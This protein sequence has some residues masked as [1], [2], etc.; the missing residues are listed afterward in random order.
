MKRGPHLRQDER[1]ASRRPC[2]GKASHRLDP[3]APASGWSTTGMRVSRSWRPEVQTRALEGLGCGAGP[4]GCPRVACPLTQ[5]LSQGVQLRGTL[6][7][8][9]SRPRLDPIAPQALPPN[10]IKLGV[11]LHLLVWGTQVRPSQSNR[12]RAG[13]MEAAHVTAS[14]ACV[15][16]TLP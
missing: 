3:I 10:A 11:G 4:L 8:V 6:P 7:L 15:L 16:G 5:P 14:P 2:R 9:T 13:Q 1:G 12:R